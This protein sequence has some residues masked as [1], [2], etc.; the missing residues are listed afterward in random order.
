[1]KRRVNSFYDINI[2][3][4]NNKLL[5]MYFQLS[6]ILNKSQNATGLIR[7]GITENQ[8]FS[9]VLVFLRALQYIICLMRRVL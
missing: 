8:F 2:V 5:L 3:A 6:F 7:I 4:K 9:V 1:M